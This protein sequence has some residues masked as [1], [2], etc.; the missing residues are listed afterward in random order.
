MDIIVSQV[1]GR[2]PVTVLR[3]QE[4]VNLGNAQELADTARQAVE[5]G[6]QNLLV[7]LTNVPSITSAG[8][9]TIQIISKLL[10]DAP[11]EMGGEAAQTEPASMGL[12]SRHLKL[13]NPS[14]YVLQVLTTAGFNLFLD[15]YD[16]L[17]AAIAA[18]Q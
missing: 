12:K 1:Q 18:F 15:I 5:N 8:L 14:P 13:V 17:P 6:T 7:D 11:T 3:I 4:R 2:V 9:R 10:S 16:N